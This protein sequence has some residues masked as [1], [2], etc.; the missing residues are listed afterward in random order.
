MDKLSGRL[1]KNKKNKNLFCHHSFLIWFSSLLYVKWLSLLSV[2]L[3]LTFLA[4]QV[5]W[6]QT[7]LT[8]LCLR[9]LISLAILK[10]KFAG[11]RILYWWV[12]YYVAL[13]ISYHSLLAYIV[14]E[15]KL[16]IIL[17]FW[18]G[19]VFP[20]LSSRFFLNLFLQ[21]EYNMPRDRFRHLSC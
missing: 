5:C 16:H 2:E 21:F 15:E 14:S 12:F 19:K 13:S 18:L 6:P 3:L 4:R 10:D 1:T 9:V 7:L 20:P 11:Q 8:W 17:I